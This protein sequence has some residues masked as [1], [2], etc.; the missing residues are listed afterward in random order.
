MQIDV[1]FPVRGGPLPIDHAYPLYAAL[2]KVVPGFHDPGEP[3][4][5]A[6]ITGSREGPG[7]LGLHDRSRLRVRLPGERI[8]AV[9]PLAGRD[10]LLG[11]DRIHLGVPTVAPLRPAPLLAAGVVTYKNATDP[12][13]FLEQTRRRL[14]EMGVAGEAGVPLVEKGPRAGE[15]RRRILRVKGRKIIGFALRVGGL[16]AEESVR[17]QELGLGGR[18]RM[19]CGF[20][21]PYRPRVS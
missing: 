17:L 10:L 18:R 2:A 1:S 5:F 7:R 19:G 12:A 16:T 8:A 21:V 20:F 14:D 9:L 6:P 13:R 3:F 15:P 11:G 4:A